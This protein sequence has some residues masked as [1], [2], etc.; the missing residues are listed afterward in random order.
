MIIRTLTFLAVIV[1]ILIEVESDDG[2]ILECRASGIF[3]SIT[4]KFLLDNGVDVRFSN[5]I[6]FRNNA[7]C[8]SVKSADGYN[9]IIPAPFDTCGTKLEHDTG[10]YIYTN[11]IVIY[12]ID[13]ESDGGEIVERGLNRIPIQCSYDDSYVVSS[14]FGLKPYVR[15]IYFETAKGNISVDMNLYQRSD[16]HPKSRLGARPMVLVSFPLYVSVNM[17]NIFGDDKITTTL[18]QCYATDKASFKDMD[19]LL[20]YL[21]QGRCIS[22][23]DSTVEI[24]Q[25]GVANEARFKFDMFRWRM[26]K[27][28]FVYLHCEVKVCDSNKESCTG[29][30]PQCNGASGGESSRKR[31]N[32]GFDVKESGITSIGPI[33]VGRLEGDGEAK[34]DTELVGV[35]RDQEFLAIYI[36]LAVGIVLLLFIIILTCTLVVKRSRQLK[37]QRKED[38]PTPVNGGRSNSETSSDSFNQNQL[39]ICF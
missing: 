7:N 2:L 32:V 37:S 33:A 34:V 8:S 10:N 24:Y 28:E 35:K 23:D 13:D 18:E 19:S 38:E 6:H 5:Q 16:Y 3:V 26:S 31:R 9:L 20:H 17:D 39:P 4:N 36:Y 21:V 22:P 15:T 27:T 11:E 14:D 30:G 12:P 29:D 1:S 25:N